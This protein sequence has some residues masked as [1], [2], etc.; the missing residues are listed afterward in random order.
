VE[1]VLAGREAAPLP[2]PRHALVVRASA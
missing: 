2:V 1:A